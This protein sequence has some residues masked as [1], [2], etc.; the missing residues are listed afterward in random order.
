MVGLAFAG[1]R[2]VHP[3]PAYAGPNNTVTAD[4]IIDGA[5]RAVIPGLVNIH[6]HPEHEPLYRGIREEHGLPSMHMTGLYERSQALSA[7]DDEARAASAEAAYCELLHSGVTTLVDVSP[8]WNGWVELFAR[9]GL[10]G[11]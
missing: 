11:F 1:D 5:N 8:P 3:G 10:R 9:S 7:P 6:S 4:Y 2:I